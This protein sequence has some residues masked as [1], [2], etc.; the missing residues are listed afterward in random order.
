ME[1]LQEKGFVRVSGARRWRTT[2]SIDL[3][4]SMSWRFSA[5]FLS[6]AVG[7]LAHRADKE[8]LRSSLTDPLVAS[9]PL[10]TD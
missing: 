9:F 4:C 8:T 1:D 2:T 6:M 5:A 10:L 7:L 3:L